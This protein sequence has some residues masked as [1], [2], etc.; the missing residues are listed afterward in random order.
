M[1]MILS[2]EATTSFELAKNLKQIVARL[3]TRLK[4]AKKSGNKKTIAK[5]QRQI[6]FYKKRYGKPSRQP[7]RTTAPQQ[8]GD[9]VASFDAKKIVRQAYLR[10]LSRYPNEREMQ[11]ASKYLDSSANTING[12]RNLIWVLLNTKEF[13]VNH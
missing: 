6:N 12:V 5:I 11:A 3:Q 1:V 4:Q 13:I 7:T 8:S 2:N 9:K 10:T